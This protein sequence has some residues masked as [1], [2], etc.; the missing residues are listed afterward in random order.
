MSTVSKLRKTVQDGTLTY[1][2]WSFHRSSN[3]SI[4]PA[5]W[6]GRLHRWRTSTSIHCTKTYTFSVRRWMASRTLRIGLTILSL[7]KGRSWCFI[8]V[9]MRAAGELE[10]LIYHPVWVHIKGFEYRRAVK[11]GN[12]WWIGG[13]LLL[14]ETPSSGLILASQSF[15]TE[16]N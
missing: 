6:R 12:F 13:H 4:L 7:P 16:F 15:I 14:F 10:S 5:Q 2:Q 3:L 9:A 11:H 1:F 8:L